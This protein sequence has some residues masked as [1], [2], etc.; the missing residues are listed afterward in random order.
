MTS[1][2]LIYSWVYIVYT[3][4]HKIKPTLST[5]I[6]LSSA[7]ILSF[8][9]NYQKTGI[10]GIG[11][12]AYN[13]ID[14]IATLC[15]LIVTRV[16]NKSKVEFNNL[17]KYC[18]IIVLILGLI[19]LLSSYQDS[20]HILIQIILCI[21]YIPMVTKYRWAK[22]HTESLIVWSIN[23]VWSGLWLIQP[24]LHNDILPI[25]YNTRSTLCALLVFI[26]LLRIELNQKNKLASKN[27]K[28]SIK[29]LK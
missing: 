9:I 7:I 11:N 18:T 21:A 24:I 29:E 10:W 8:I 6:F 17:E 5:W 25:I 1:T 3:V 26:L 28:D 2:I 4:Q 27:I 19:W 16:T 15:I 20:S 23:T 22:S 13:L 12:N 14:G